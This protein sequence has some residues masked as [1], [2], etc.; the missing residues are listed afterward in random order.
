MTH[1]RRNPN[2]V[3]AIRASSFFLLPRKET[4]GAITGVSYLGPLQAR[5]RQAYHFDF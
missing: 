1:Q 3:F 4:K 5:L 2:E